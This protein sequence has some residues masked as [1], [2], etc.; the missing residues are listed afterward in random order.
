M[1]GLTR[2]SAGP[3]DHELLLEFASHATAARLPR[4]AQW[5]PGDIAWATRCGPLRQ[6]LWRDGD[7]IVAAGWFE[8]PS[9]LWLETLDEAVV[10]DILR[11]AEREPYLGAAAELSVRAF[12]SD[13]PRIAAFEALGYR[14]AR[15]DGVWFERVLAGGLG[16]APAPE[17]FRVRDAR[18]LDPAHRVAIHADTWSDL[19]HL[20]IPLGR[21]DFTAAKYDAVRASPAYDPELDLVVEAADGTLAACALAWSDAVAGVGIFEPMGTHPAWRGR[22]LAGLLIAEGFRRLKAKGCR[23]ARIGTAHFNASAMAAHSRA[24]SAPKDRTL[25]WSKVLNA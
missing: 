8:T 19:T 18:G 13:A 4:F 5:H 6:T 21:S 11:W 25:W 7:R 2:H 23:L 9:E 17:G 24:V 10:P 16:D 22:G 1:A 14:L 3:D 15:P 20:G 12:E